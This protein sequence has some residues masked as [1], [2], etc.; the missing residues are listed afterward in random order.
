MQADMR[1]ANAILIALACALSCATAAGAS[2]GAVADP[3]LAAAGDIACPP[4]TPVTKRECQQDATASLI[5]RYRPSAVALL[6]DD[7]YEA[8]TLEEFMGD[9]AFNDT[10]GRFKSS[11][12][13]APGNHEYLASP[14]ARGYFEYFGARAGPPGQG[15]YSYEVG[16]WHVLSLN[17]ACSD[18]GCAD[19]RLGTVTTAEIDWLR[20]DL[21][22]HPHQ[23]ILAYWH[24]PRFSSGAEG[25]E[26]GVKPL[27]TALYEAGA[28]VV[29]NGHDHDYERFAPQDPN[30][31]ATPRGIRE[32][33]VGTGGKDHYAFHKDVLANSRFRD[34]THFGALFLTLHR[35]GYQ[36]RFR[37]TT[38]EVLD[39]GD[40]ACHSA[41][42]K[43]AS[44]RGRAALGR[45]ELG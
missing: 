24:H 41:P 1:K 12:W 7:Q 27:W 4:Q 28:D 18:A 2:A 16:A 20:E 26:P 11:I 22:H 35:H 44:R 17:S 19:R 31:H 13:P 10:W 3:V 33:V 6:G 23:C 15:Y 45:A 38:G 25:D 32:F 37:A 9:G 40:S 14:A 21:S 8:G 43:A 42:R 30:G 39:S 34:H 5:E 36:W 29:L